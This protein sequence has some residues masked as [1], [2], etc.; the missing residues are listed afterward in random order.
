MNNKVSKIKVAV[1]A[2]VFGYSRT[3][4]VSV[5]LIKRKY[6]P[7]QNSWAIPGGFVLDHESLEEAVHRERQV[8][9]RSA[10]VEHREGHVVGGKVRVVLV[11]E[12]GARVGRRDLEVAS[13]AKVP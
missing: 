4:G 11:G 3:D 9:L 8:G 13:A 2:I 1:D 6:A 5:L 12:P 10:A 7:F